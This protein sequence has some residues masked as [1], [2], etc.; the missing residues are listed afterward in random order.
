MDLILSNSSLSGSIGIPF[1]LLPKHEGVT[2][3]IDEEYHRRK[4]HMFPNQPLVWRDLIA[5]DITNHLGQSNLSRVGV[6]RS[7][8]LMKMARRS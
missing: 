7:S 8:R 3:E 4:F 2:R 6:I 5:T 1:A